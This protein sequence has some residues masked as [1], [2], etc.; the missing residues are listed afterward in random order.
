M[1]EGMLV[2]ERG[3]PR[4]GPLRTGKSGPPAVRRG[5]P[6]S[7]PRSETRSEPRSE[8]SRTRTSD[9]WRI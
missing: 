3:S 4:S 5:S 1:R 9:W 6:R 7:K 2:H 8:P